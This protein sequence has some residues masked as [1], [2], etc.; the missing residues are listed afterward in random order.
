MVIST[1]ICEFDPLHNG[2]KYILDCMRESGAECIVACMSGNFT[3][4]GSPAYFDKHSRA[5]AALNCGADLV[6]ELPVTFACAGAERF[7]FGGVSILN[8][9][10]CADS[11]FFG[12]ECGSTELLRKAALALEGDAV[13]GRIREK[14]VTGVTFAAAREQA[15]REICGDEAADALHRPNDILGIE[16]LK[17]LS[18]LK[19][20]ITPHTVKRL[21]ALHDSAEADGGFASASRLRELALEGASIQE[22]VPAGA[23][24]VFGRS[25][26]G[27]QPDR[28]KALERVMLYRLRMMTLSDMAV[29]PEIGEGLENRLYSAVRSGISVSEILASVKT[30]RY[31]MARLRRI[32]T[33]ALL[34]ITAS[35]M[36]PSPP[37]I[38]VLGFNGTGRL[39]LSEIKKRS[40]LPIITKVSELSKLNDA[41]RRAF[42]LE[43][44]CDD[45]YAISGEAVRP[46][47]TNQTSQLISPGGKLPRPISLPVQHI[48]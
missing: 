38:R 6:T 20:S 8:A 25:L 42:D 31:T 14:L 21:G 23:F 33:Y 18:L 32:L 1:I 16:Y 39:A 29:L 48:L 3:Q 26:A 11:I 41:C 17:A 43:S 36:L 35:D 34:G 7:A 10:G 44:R 15:V 2:H 46:C 30:K 22:Y 4:R 27:A 5:E 12:S 24:E 9:L 47:G 13:K 37:Y 45:I 40:S 19:S 28:M